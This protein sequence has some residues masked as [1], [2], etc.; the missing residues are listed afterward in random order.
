MANG[1]T[2]MDV[3]ESRSASAGQWPLVSVVTLNFNGRRFLKGLFDSLRACTYPH[4]EILMVDNCSDDDSVAFVR[5]NYP[6]VRI[7]E[8]AENYMY[9]GGNNEGIRH[10]RGKYICVLNNDVEVDPG[11]IEPVIEVLENDPEV[12]A[13]QSKLLGL[14]QRHMLE[15]AGA[16]GGFIDW[17]GYPFLRGRVFF[18]TEED[19]GQYDEPVEIF[20]ASGACLFLRRE[21]IEECGLLDEDFVMHQEE[22]DL[23]WR[24]HLRNWKIVCV[25][26]SRVWH[27]VGGTLDQQSPRKTYWNFRNNMFLLIKNLSL[28]GLLLRLPLRLPLDMVAMGVEFLKGH[29]TNGLAILKAYGWLLS[30]PGLILRK[31]REVQRLRRAPDREAL[32]LM[33]PGSIVVE[34]FLLGR[35]KFSQ[36]R[37]ISR[38]LVPYRAPVP[39]ENP[40]G[41][42]A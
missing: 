21:A 30:H 20:W 38:I 12:G 6:E 1:R 35:R 14:Q 10:A 31:R 2:N 23:C 26:A 36:L 16:C 42:S 13:A 33:Y 29:F 11:F 17:L 7:I 40:G 41:E 39:A 19:Q 37:R 34:Y 32:R 24:L 3:T 5:E 22:I 4:L 18:T 15:Y 28:P 9:S 8:N 27:Y 25:P